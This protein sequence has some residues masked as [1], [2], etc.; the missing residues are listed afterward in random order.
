MHSSTKCVV[1]L[2]GMDGSAPEALWSHRPHPSHSPFSFPC[3]SPRWIVDPQLMAMDSLGVG[4]GSTLFTSLWLIHILTFTVAI[5]ESQFNPSSCL[6][7]GPHPCIPLISLFSV[8]AI[9]I[10]Q[11]TSPI[12]LQPVVVSLLSLPVVVSLLSLLGKWFGIREA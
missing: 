12:G 5:Q 2:L 6:V 1:V 7:P 10:Q 9:L 8:P 3:G 4:L 11:V